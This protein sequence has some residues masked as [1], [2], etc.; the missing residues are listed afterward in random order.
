MVQPG[1]AG[2]G[3]VHVFENPPAKVPGASNVPFVISEIA[4][5][6]V[7]HRAR[8]MMMDAPNAAHAD[9]FFATRFDPSDPQF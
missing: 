8:M 3:E 9:R 5:A 2:Q 7:A 6:G 4:C 1:S